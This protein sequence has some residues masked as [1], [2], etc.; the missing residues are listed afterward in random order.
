LVAVLCCGLLYAWLTYAA[1]VE[2]FWSPDNGGKFLQM[3]NLRWEDGLDYTID[4]PG[5]DQDP[6]LTFAPFPSA[7]SSV[8]NGRVA[9]QWSPL[10]P[11]LSAP[12]YHLWGP[13]GIHL[14]PLLTGVASLVIVLFLVGRMPWPWP[15]VAVLIT[16][17]STPL[18]FYSIEFWEHTPA[19]FLALLG[20]WALIKFRE[21][22]RWGFLVAA[23]LSLAS[24]AALR[25]ELYLAFP[26]AALALLLAS[27]QKRRLIRPAIALLGMGVLITLPV[28]AYYW[29]T[30]GRLL[31]PSA[32]NLFFPLNYLKR[33]GATAALSDFFVGTVTDGGIQAPPAWKLAFSIAGL[34]GIAGAFFPRRDN[35]T[36]ASIRKGWL[37]LS[38]TAVLITAGG[39]AFQYPDHR[40]VHGFLILCP[41]LLF[42]WVELRSTGSETRSSFLGILGSLY[43][44]LYGIA[45][46]FFRWRGPNGGLEWGPRYMLLIYPLLIP[47]AI[48]G[49]GKILSAERN[50]IW[51]TLFLSLFLL[52]ALLSIVYQVRGIRIQLQDRQDS[53]DRLA[54]LQ[55]H[56]PE[57]VV[58]D[59][60]WVPLDMATEFYKRRFF[61]VPIDT[62]LPKW[63][64]QSAQEGPVSFCLLR[65]GDISPEQLR[66]LAP[67][68]E[69]T[70]LR[71]EWAGHLS[72]AV[73]AFEPTKP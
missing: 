41:V 26:A 5:Q 30:A 21:E 42:A 23:T 45:A 46:L 24:S 69:F 7:F 71:V 18:A 31:P 63:L 35:P 32:A 9:L 60:W 38:Y 40:G 58:T 68:G 1:P 72:F 37:A 6:Q 28:L 19:L 29:F 4:Y 2:T 59:V 12:L 34:L 49:L 48:H 39:I 66:E 65:L 61:L 33:T 22:K 25:P 11:L 3:L 14:L 50:R 62:A 51:K 27:P 55:T 47:S 44:L 54:A 36:L 15:P 56:C 73:G 8:E 16:G 43:L 13:H 67:A 20:V 17:I 57:N 70:E 10:F 52:M 53:Q 64:T